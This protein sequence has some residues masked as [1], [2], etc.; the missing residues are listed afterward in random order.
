MLD[1]PTQPQAGWHL[2]NLWQSSG[3][4]MLNGFF[5]FFSSGRDDE[6]DGETAFEEEQGFEWTE[7]MRIVLAIVVTI[8][9]ALFMWWIVA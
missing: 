7:H 4:Y 5:R 1:V 6:D 9:G 3:E 8:G 2:P